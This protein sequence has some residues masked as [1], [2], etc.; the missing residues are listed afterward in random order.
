ME[1][2]L[3]PELKKYLEADY[4][5][6]RHVPGH[7]ICGIRRQAFTVGLFEGLTKWSYDGRYCFPTAPEARAALVAWSGGEP[8]PPGEWIKYIGYRGE[9]RR[10][11]DPFEQ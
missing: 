4:A 10:I 5:D 6:L 3:T 7:G 9:Y 2:L 8:D 11:P 1:E